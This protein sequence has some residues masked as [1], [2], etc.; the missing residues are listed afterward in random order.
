MT[1]RRAVLL[2]PIALALVACG[3]APKPGDGKAPAEQGK[4]GDGPGP[5][6]APGGGSGEGATY[7][8]AKD[9]LVNPASL[10]EP[11]DAARCAE[12][13]TLVATLDGSPQTLNPMFAS[14]TYEFR[15]AELMW[16]SPF[17]FD[18]NFNWKVDEDVVESWNVSDDKKTWTVKLKPGATW[19]DGAPWTAHD[20]VWS[21]GQQ[22]DTRVPSTD[23]EG[24]L[25]LESVTALD[26]LTVQYVLK[27]PTPMSKWD[28]SGINVIPKH[29]FEKG[30]ADDPTMKN[31]DYYSK[32]N[33]QIVGSGAYR[34]VEWKENDKIVLERWPGYKGKHA[35]FKRIVFRIIPERGVQLLTFE[36]G[37]IDE[38][39]LMSKEFALETVRSQTFK[40]IG[41]KSKTPQ[42]LYNY[43]V[44]NTRGNPFF[45]DAKVRRAMTMAM[46][47]QQI[48]EKITYRIGET[49]YG[50]YHPTAWFYNP[51]I[52][53]LPYDP[54]GA[55]KLLDEAGWRID[56][57]TGWRTK[58]GTPFSFTMTFGQGNPQTVDMLTIIQQSLKSIGVE[59]KLR[60]VEWA[61]F[62]EQN[63]KHEFQASTA[64]WG[65]GAD[66][67][68]GENTF[69]TKA[70]DSGRNYGC[71]SNP[72]IDELY[73]LT[74][75]EFDQEKRAAHFREIN[76][77][78]YDDQTYTFLYSLPCLWAFNK[79]IRGVTSSPRGVWNFDPS[80]NAWWVT[81]EQQ[82]Y[83]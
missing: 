25:R 13:E 37:E 18:A 55:G 6:A 50:P 77:I 7:D 10:R 63:R 19:H 39:R 83:K 20:F 1:P 42:W 31:S 51:N 11:H 74:L 26:D 4:P 35:H 22:K 80:V 68:Y 34:F 61:T 9:P 45:G 27:E 23:P 54:A 81:K 28:I 52:K 59:M 17:T 70:I 72:R 69:T 16:R 53:L 43:I 56:D 12:D 33:R 60:P 73:Q 15:F 64:A 57:N 76:Q 49:A 67:Q 47:L 36:K 30:L 38:M 46:N 14:S 82:L 58:D 5:A 65:P 32:Q 8:P 75:R 78:V 21:W 24:A 29:V 48:I 66:P 44:W 3:E 2:L 62:Q 41:V 71:Y 79:R 40:D